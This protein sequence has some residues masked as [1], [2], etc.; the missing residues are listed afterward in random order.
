MT[1]SYRLAEEDDFDAMLPL[2]AE[3]HAENAI[4]LLDIG[5][6][7]QNIVACASRGHVLIAEDDG[8][9]VGILPLLVSQWFFSSE[10]FIVDMCFYVR[11]DHRDASSI[12]RHLLNWALSVGDTVGLPVYI[13]VNNPGKMKRRGRVATIEG[14]VP[15]GYVL[16]L[17]KGG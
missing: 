5:V 12:G 3:F 14:F 2:L 16:R 9:V 7:E 4:A 8:E 10:H 13:R 1:I 17:S 6:L 15:I 11:P